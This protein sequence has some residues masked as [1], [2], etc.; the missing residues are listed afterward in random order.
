MEV[1]QNLG[2][3]NM[4]INIKSAGLI[5]KQETSILLINFSE[6]LRVLTGV[7]KFSLS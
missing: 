2:N 3:K 7:N 4:C 6:I 1:A 5:K